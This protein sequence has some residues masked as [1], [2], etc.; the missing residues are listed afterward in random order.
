MVIGEGEGL[1]APQTACDTFAG[2]QELN[3]PVEVPLKFEDYRIRLERK[4]VRL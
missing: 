4:K 3:E 1:S 2:L